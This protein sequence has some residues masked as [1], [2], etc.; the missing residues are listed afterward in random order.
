M[1]PERTS[2]IERV[3]PA[4]NVMVLLIPVLLVGLEL[5][6]LAA[7]HSSIP[8]FNPDVAQI[9]TPRAPRPPQPPIRDA[10]PAPPPSPPEAGIDDYSTLPSAARSRPLFAD[11]LLGY[12]P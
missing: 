8:D 2:M 12:G 1:R 9:E 10:S 5:T 3:L 7:I 11:P 6:S 4:L